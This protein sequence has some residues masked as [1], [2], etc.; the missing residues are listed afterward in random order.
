MRICAWAGVPERR[1]AE[2]ARGHERRAGELQPSGAVSGVVDVRREAGGDALEHLVG[3]R[4]RG[5]EGVAAGGDSGGEQKCDG[6][7]EDVRN[8][9]VARVVQ[10]TVVVGVS[11][12]LSP[13]AEGCRGVDWKCYSKYNPRVPPERDKDRIVE[14]CPLV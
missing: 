5:A 9:L 8:S 7:A 13:P 12:L 14:H 2:D 6:G 3:M 4:G 11:G 10:T 1:V